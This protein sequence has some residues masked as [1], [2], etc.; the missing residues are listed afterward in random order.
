[1][2]LNEQIGTYRRQKGMTQEELAGKLGVT[3]QAVSKWESGQCCPDVALLPT[4]A[5]IFGVTIDTLMGREAPDSFAG[6]YANT[7]AYFSAVSEEELHRDAFRLSILLHESLCTNGFRRTVPFQPDHGMEIRPPKWGYSIEAD[8]AGCGVYAGCGILLTYHP[9]WTMPNAGK[10]WQ[11][12]KKLQSLAD[13]MT[14][15]VLFTLFAL[16]YRD[17][18]RYVSADAIA[19]EA[20]LSVDEVEKVLS[21]IDVTVQ[22]QGGKLVYRLAGSNM[23]LPVLLE[24]LVVS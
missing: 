11:I 16:T 9:A 10:L 6:L 17:E 19:K 13:G 8:P 7:K 24:M 18:D 14:L 1:M 4:L 15:S 23:Y 5:D 22:E 12:Q 21:T 3:G 2:K 20:R